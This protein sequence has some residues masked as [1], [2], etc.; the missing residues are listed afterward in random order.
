MAYYGNEPAKVAVKVGSGVIT[1][2]ELADDSITTADIIADAITPTELDDDGTGFQVGTLGVGAAVSGGHTLLVNGTSSLSGNV[3]TS[4][5]FQSNASGIGFRLANQS[6]DSLYYSATNRIGFSG[7][8]TQRFQSTAAT[9]TGTIGSGAITSTAGISGTTGTFSGGVNFTGG[10]AADNTLYK[11]SNNYAYLMG[12]TAGLVLK[13][14]NSDDA[15]IY[16][17]NSGQYV[18]FTTNNTERFKVDNSGAT[19]SGDVAVGG[20]STGIAN[21]QLHVK[22]FTSGHDGGIRIERN[23][24]GYSELRHAGGT[25]E[26]FTV[27]NNVQ[28]SPIRVFV[29]DG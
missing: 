11:A 17:G 14:K 10:S 26:G 27:Y 25:S 6:Y 3:F 5:Y 20:G 9:F 7:S 1:A 18:L 23:G 19:F 16:L 13:G 15:N 22:S 8:T 24:E 29:Y 2:T 21:G 28:D 12:G 4:G